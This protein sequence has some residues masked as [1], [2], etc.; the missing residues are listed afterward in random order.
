MEGLAVDAALFAPP[1][2][3]HFRYEGSTT[4]PPCEEP[5]RWYVMRRPRT[6]SSPQVD[7]LLELTRG[8]N[9]RPLQPRGNRVIIRA[10]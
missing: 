6:I 10:G 8:P 4:T 1:G 7:R 9:N 3:G 2:G 5:V